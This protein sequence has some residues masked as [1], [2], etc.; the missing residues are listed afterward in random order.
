MTSALSAA[1]EVASPTLIYEDDSV[2]VLRNPHRSD[3]VFVS[4]SPWSSSPPAPLFGA[5]F[6]DA[7]GAGAVFVQSKANDWFQSSDPERLASVV[8]NATPTSA[9]RIAYGSSMGGFGALTIGLAAGCDD[10]IAISPQATIDRAHAPWET[11]WKPEAEAIPAFRYHVGSLR[12]PASRIHLIFD[13]WM[14]LDN[15]QAQYVERA[16]ERTNTIYSWRIG[17]SGHPSG[18]ALAETRLLK[19]LIVD[20]MNGAYNTSGLTR[21]FRAARRVSHAVAKSL[22]TNRAILARHK[23]LVRNG[24]AFIDATKRLPAHLQDKLRDL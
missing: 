14:K 6:F 7:I 20:I 9:R 18:T 2:V 10:A 16:F 15:L 24:V 1:A 8:R 4:F 12:N 11:R 17:L 22:L 23:G 3:T 19:P 13:P 21:R 5:D